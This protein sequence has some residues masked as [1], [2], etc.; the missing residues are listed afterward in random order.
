MLKDG[1]FLEKY[2][3]AVKEKKSIININLDPALPRQRKNFV[4]QKNI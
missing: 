2:K 3:N 1:M 4:I